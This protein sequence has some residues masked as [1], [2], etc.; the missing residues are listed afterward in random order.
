[1]F[2]LVMGKKEG[3]HGIYVELHEG[4]SRAVWGRFFPSGQ[5]DGGSIQTGYAQ[6]LH[7]FF[8]LIPHS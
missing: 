2:D 6:L 3:F 8:A 1:M 7:G 4:A 5:Q